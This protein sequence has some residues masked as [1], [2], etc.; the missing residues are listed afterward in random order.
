M[1]WQTGKYGYADAVK[2]VK[3]KGM[4]SIR[5][6][7][8]I[9]EMDMAFGAADVIV[10]RAGAGTISEL[11][12]VGKPVILV[13]SPNVAEDH[14]TRNAEAL[15]SRR[16]AKM[17][18]DNLAVEHLVNKILKLVDDRKQRDELSRNIQQM[19]L[20]DSAEHIADEILKILA[21]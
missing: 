19:A 5:V 16:A 20:P 15:V 6:M 14:Q 3:D 11:C 2:A 1:I 10:S 17:V 4:G 9:S 8:F 7:A 13:P 12:L 21:S 18:P